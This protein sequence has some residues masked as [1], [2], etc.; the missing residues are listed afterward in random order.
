[1]TAPMETPRVPPSESIRFRAPVWTRWSDEDNQGV[2]NNAVYLTLLEESRHRYF[3]RLGLVGADNRFSFLLGQTNLRF[4]APG[5]GPAE[6]EVEVATTRLGTKS[7]AQAYR[8]REA[9]GGRVWLEAEAALVI[10]D[11]QARAT[12]PIPPAFRRAVAEFEG[13]E[14]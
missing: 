5:R 14:A 8:V 13:L 10:W 11:E 3:S 4:L 7:F 1:M 12:A 2:L 9:G 6:V